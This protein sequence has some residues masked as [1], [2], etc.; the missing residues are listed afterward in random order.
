MNESEDVCDINNGQ[1]VMMATQYELKIRTCW[2]MTYH[3]LSSIPLVSFQY[4]QQANVGQTSIGMRSRM[5]VWTISTLLMVAMMMVP[6]MNLRAMCRGIYD[7]TVYCSSKLSV[8]P[9]ATLPQPHDLHL[10]HNT[11][12]EEKVASSLTVPY[13]GR[14]CGTFP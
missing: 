13:Q 12:N 10:C 8:L 2:I 4:I 1:D 6:T 3:F 11:L 9:S 5:G 7:R 14:V